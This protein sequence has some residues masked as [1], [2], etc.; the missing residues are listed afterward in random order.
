MEGSVIHSTGALASA[1]PERLLGTGE[2][3][4][5][6][7]T[8]GKLFSHSEYGEFWKSDGGTEIDAK[9]Y[10]DEYGS[11]RGEHYASDLFQSRVWC[12]GNDVTDERGTWAE[13]QFFSLVERYDGRHGNG[14]TNDPGRFWN[15]AERD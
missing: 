13:Q 11:G 9:H 8:T 4:Y 7:D 15:L 12:V 1:G 10:A 3:K 14:N 5:T 2:R 6:A